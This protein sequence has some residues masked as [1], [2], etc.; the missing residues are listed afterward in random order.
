MVERQ[1]IGRDDYFRRSHGDPRGMTVNCDRFQCGLE[2]INCVRN[3]RRFGRDDF[4]RGAAVGYRHIAEVA[5]G[6]GF[7]CPDFQEDEGAEVFLHRHV[8]A[9]TESREPVVKLLLAGR[10]Q[11]CG[12]CGD[13]IASTYIVAIGW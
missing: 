11:I 3:R 7:L 5:V 1:Q 6:L 12:F 8:N 4:E 2:N 9:L 10:E 13:E